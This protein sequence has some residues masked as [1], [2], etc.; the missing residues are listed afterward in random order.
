MALFGLAFMLGVP[1]V[2]RRFLNVVFDI[3]RDADPAALRALGLLGV[4]IGVALIY[5]GAWV[6]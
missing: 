5:L 6:L 2:Y 3:A 1:A 4:L